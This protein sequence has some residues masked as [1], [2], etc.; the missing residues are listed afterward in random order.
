MLTKI[1]LKKMFITS[2]IVII[3]LL[4]YF[5]PGVVELDNNFKTSVEYVD[6]T[7][8]IIYLVDNDGFLVEATIS[9][10][11]VENVE[12]KIRD[13]LNHLSDASDEV[14]PNG[15]NHVFN[16]N[17]Y[18]IDVLVDE[19]I[20]SLNFSNEL[21]ELSKKEMIRFIE[22]VSYT[23]INNLDINGVGI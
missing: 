18:L 16:S 2:S 11:D 17:I 4:V 1:L 21:L 13:L 10:I 5:M 6:L 8:N 19:N 22:A 7:N 14:I 20:A 9:T 3:I 23:I 12:E 15:L